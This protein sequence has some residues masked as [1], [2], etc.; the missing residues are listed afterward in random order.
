MMLKICNKILNVFTAIILKRFEH[1]SRFIYYF[2]G[3]FYLENTN[4]SLNVM[5]SYF[6]YDE[7]F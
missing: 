5:N 1:K 2:F 7:N 4:S 3:E 6:S